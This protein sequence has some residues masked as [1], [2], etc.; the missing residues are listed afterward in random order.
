MCSVS[1]CECVWVCM[2]VCGSTCAYKLCICVCA[3]AHACVHA[4]VCLY[5]CFVYVHTCALNLPSSHDIQKTNTVRKAT[6]H[7]MFWLCTFNGTDLSLIDPRSKHCHFTLQNKP[8]FPTTTSPSMKT[9]PA[10]SYEWAKHV[11]TKSSSGGNY[12]VK[13]L[14]YM[15]IQHIQRNG[16]HPEVVSTLQNTTHMQQ[17]HNVV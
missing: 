1:A 17:F 8:P 4:R 9:I 13:F 14:P 3:H 10:K 6:T 11:D 5:M 16:C 7:I 15:C 2:C 12:L